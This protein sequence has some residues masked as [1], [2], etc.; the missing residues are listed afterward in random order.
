MIR[1]TTQSGFEFVIE[2]SALDD[3]ELLEA[4]EELDSNPG[5]F[6]KVAKSLLSNEYYNALKKHCTKNGKVVMH[7]V[8]AEI[9]EMLNS[10]KE[11]K[12]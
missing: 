2:D 11:I 9:E 6:V 8:I 7:K 10:N 4:M 1:G 3:W 12:N 5:A